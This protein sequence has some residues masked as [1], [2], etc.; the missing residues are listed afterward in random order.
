MQSQFKEKQLQLTLEQL[1]HNFVKVKPPTCCEVDDELV[2][3]CSIHDDKKRLLPL[4]PML[5]LLNHYAQKK[6]CGTVDLLDHGERANEK[7]V[8]AY[9]LMRIIFDF[10]A[11]GDLQR[12]EEDFKDRLVHFLAFLESIHQTPRAME[13][14]QSPSLS[15]VAKRMAIYLN[16]IIAADINKLS[17]EFLVENKLAVF[18]RFDALGGG[19][20]EQGS[21]WQSL[22]GYLYEKFRSENT[23][24]LGRIVPREVRYT[25]FT[26]LYSDP[27]KSYKE[28]IETYDLRFSSDH[29]AVDVM[30][31]LVNNVANYVEQVVQKF[32]EAHEVSDVIQGSVV[33]EVIALFYLLDKAIGLF[34]SRNEQSSYGSHI[35]MIEI[36]VTDIKALLSFFMREKF[37][38]LWTEKSP[39]LLGMASIKAALFNY[40]QLPVNRTCRLR[41]RYADSLDCY[42]ASVV[43][44]LS[45]M[46]FLQDS[47]E[48][49]SLVLDRFIRHVE[50]PLVGFFGGEGKL[51]KR[52]VVRMMYSPDYEAPKFTQYKEIYEVLVVT[53][54][55]FS[56]ALNNWQEMCDSSGG[57]NEV[58]LKNI[59][60]IQSLLAEVDARLCVTRDVFNEF[61][62][63]D[64]KQS[65]KEVGLF[66]QSIDVRCSGLGALQEAG[67]SEEYAR[68]LGELS[69]ANKAFSKYYP[70]A[71]KP[72][73]PATPDRSIVATLVRMMPGSAKKAGADDTSFISSHLEK[74]PSRANGSGS[75]ESVSLP[76][77]LPLSAAMGGQSLMQFG[78][79]SS[80]LGASPPRSDKKAFALP[81]S[82]NK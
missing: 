75:V 30:L 22:F 28:K 69:A 59:V 12:S 46:K 68:P 60:T 20:A 65:F 6:G 36:F 2:A 74:S 25:S 29:A 52:G 24:G 55:C 13:Y 37:A 19:D 81:G 80:V 54:S 71:M 51:E 72:P 26:L 11:L 45:A 40:L 79:G 5:A 9:R 39:Y 76:P 18:K 47:V 64:S 56:L 43:N 77:P 53:M 41:R 10:H 34:V 15:V 3:K 44:L 61:R 21:Y 58:A 27:F 78:V 35:A 50:T 73:A 49:D 38:A 48:N 23:S 4:Q 16:V 1:H 63:A 82:C 62:R 7:D 42:H 32:S 17:F 33:F 66:Q 70:Q 57:I 67:A 31:L 14:R 8:A